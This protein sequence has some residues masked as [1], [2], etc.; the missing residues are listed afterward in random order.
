MK[1]KDRALF[2]SVYSASDLKLSVKHIQP[3]QRQV[4]IAD[5]VASKSCNHSLHRGKPIK[6]DAKPVDAFP[7]DDPYFQEML[8]IEK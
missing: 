3:Q 5:E 6:I 1:F 2:V 8:N 4:R 7:K